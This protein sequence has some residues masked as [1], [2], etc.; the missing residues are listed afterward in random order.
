MREHGAA[1][2]PA[3]AAPGHRAASGYDNPHRHPGHVN[4]QDHLPETVGD[5]RFYTPDD[6]EETLA[7]RHAAA[8]RARGREA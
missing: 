6:A 5:V 1:D 2:P 4:T 8:R 7:Q 3:R